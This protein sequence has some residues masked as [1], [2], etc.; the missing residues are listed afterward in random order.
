MV[1]WWIKIE[2]LNLIPKM[3]IFDCISRL[4]RWHFSLP[5][6]HFYSFCISL[7]S[8]YKDKSH[9]EF[10][11]NLLLCYLLLRLKIIVFNCESSEGLGFPESSTVWRAHLSWRETHSILKEFNKDPPPWPTQEPQLSGTAL[12]CI[13]TWCWWSYSVNIETKS[14]YIRIVFSPIISRGTWWQWTWGLCSWG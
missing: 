5:C 12:I 2:L 9:A 11:N 14:M 7:L 4:D 6:R 1:K 10:H 3:V 13:Q 8:Q